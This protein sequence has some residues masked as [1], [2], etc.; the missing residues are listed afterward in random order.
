MAVDP[1]GTTGLAARVD[2]GPYQ[3]CVC[4]TDGEVLRFI[5]DSEPDVVVIER[6]ISSVRI[7]ADGLR[8]VELVGKVEGL[9]WHLGIP[10][11]VHTPAMRRAAQR[12]AEEA[13]RA[14][15]RTEGWSAHQA[16][17]LAHLMMYERRTRAR[18]RA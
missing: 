9:C 4:H 15:R 11:V 1:G 14:L 2:D 8:T 10:V 7:S 5:V 13:V 17:A 3:T 16:D 12:S 6:Y 18:L